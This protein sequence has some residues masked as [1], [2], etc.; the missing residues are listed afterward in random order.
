MSKKSLNKA[1]LIALGAERLAELLLE[2]TSGNAALQ[3]RLR[4][5]LSAAQG[6]GE[7]AQEIR[8]R[9]AALRRSTG[10]VS[11]QGRRKLVQDLNAHLTMIVENVAPDDPKTAF[12]L[13]WTLLEL[14]PGIHERADDRQFQGDRRR[15]P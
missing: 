5:E 13:L 8:K 2:V 12:D 1:N 6:P 7:V 10:F 11:W 3:R 14:A 4:L 15:V 9:F